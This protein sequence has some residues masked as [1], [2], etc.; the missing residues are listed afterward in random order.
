[1]DVEWFLLAFVWLYAPGLFVLVSVLLVGAFFW[2]RNQILSRLLFWLWLPQIVI[3]G[4]VWCIQLR[5][6]TGTFESTAPM[7]A[8]AGMASLLVFWLL[9]R[10]TTK[11]PVALCLAWLTFATTFAGI[12]P[13]NLISGTM[14]M[15]QDQQV[16]TL[17]SRTDWQNCAP[18]EQADDPELIMRAL[19]LSAEMP[20]LSPDVWR[21]LTKKVASPFGEL[22]CGDY[23]EDTPFYIAIRMRNT[24]AVRALSE[25]F[26]G[27]TPR[28]R[29]NRCIVTRNN[30]IINLIYL[31]DGTNES[32]REISDILLQ[33]MPELL[34]EEVLHNVILYGN[35]RAVR[36]A[37]AHRQPETR[38]YQLAARVKTGPVDT[39]L[40]TL[41]QHPNLLQISLPVYK[42]L[43]SFIVDQANVATLRR[44]LDS[45]LVAP[46]FY[47]DR[48]GN[49]EVLERAIYRVNS[50]IEDKTPL[51][52]V[53]RDI[54]DRKIP[55]TKQQVLHGINASSDTVL[56]AFLE[57][58]FSCQQLLAMNES[59]T[60]NSYIKAAIAGNINRVCARQN[61]QEQV[62]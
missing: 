10:W 47:L 19:T 7:F 11:L 31:G 48:D 29:E 24:A 12:N 56:E 21:C 44:V 46:A 27:D 15:Y 38:N 40:A 18:A 16:D 28:A 30:P 1:M 61:Q 34:T 51:V 9:S 14:E 20:Q 13:V 54:L 50:W 8:T 62:E 45:G 37:I 53:M 49:N 35:S 23:A 57:A 2:R 42:T 6:D 41:K 55:W 43:W 5:N 25:T 17:L 36:Y 60:Q 26:R 33:V 3:F 22:V 32:D 52:L 58:G 4:L 39:L 59:E